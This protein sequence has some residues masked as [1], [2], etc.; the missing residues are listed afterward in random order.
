MPQNVITGNKYLLFIDTEA[1]GLPLNW[2][3]PYSE[4]GNWPQ[5][6]QVSWTIYDDQRKEIKKENR[7][8]RNDH[9]HITEAAIAVHHLTTDFLSANGEKD[10]DVLDILAKDLETYQPLVI[11][12]FIKLDYYVLGAAFFRAG[13]ANPLEHLPIFCTMLASGNL[14]NNYTGRQLHLGE[15][16]TFL[17]YHELNNQHNALVDAEA[18]AACFFEMKSRGELTSGNIIQQNKA[19]DKWRDP[20]HNKRNYFSPLLLL[21]LV[22]S[23]II[24]TAYL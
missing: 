16:Y 7:Y 22:S 8:I 19:A 6:I 1:S 11:G 5:P 24:Y 3:L 14:T 13:L 21:A 2:S 4:E 9:F 15:L 18:T 20:T 12:H 17:F 10:I 23:L